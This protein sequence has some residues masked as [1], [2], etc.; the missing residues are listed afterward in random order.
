MEQ[1]PF[2]NM[3]WL[4]YSRVWLKSTLVR[5]LSCRRQVLVETDGSMGPGVR[6]ISSARCSALVL[7]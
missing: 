3:T 1:D 7:S 2:G 6:I 5:R 4:V